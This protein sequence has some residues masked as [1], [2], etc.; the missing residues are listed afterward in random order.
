MGMSMVA[1][2]GNDTGSTDSGETT[3][4]TENTDS[5]ESSDDSAAAETTEEP[6]EEAAAEDLSGAIATGGSTSV[7]DVIGSLS[8]AFMEEYRMWILH[9]IPTEAAPASPEHLTEPTIWDFPAVT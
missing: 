2:G 9:M 8:E 6:T 4:T 7:E 1:C 5:A 3:E